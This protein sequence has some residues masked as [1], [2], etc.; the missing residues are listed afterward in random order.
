LILENKLTFV[1]PDE[2]QK[3]ENMTDNLVWLGSTHNP[4]YVYGGTTGIGGGATAIGVTGCSG[5]TGAS[6]VGHTIFSVPD[7]KWYIIN[8]NLS[9][10]P[11][12]FPNS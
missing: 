7:N 9:I 10:T 4:N 6:M 11:F 12:I 1:F 2:G 3:E 5:M 8:P